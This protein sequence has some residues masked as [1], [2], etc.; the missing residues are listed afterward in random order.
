MRTY[1][2]MPGK[3]LEWEGA[4]RRGLEARRRFV[5]SRSGFSGFQHVNHG[6]VS[7]PTGVITAES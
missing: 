2:L 3:L 7:G 5:V 6:M 4:W 1:E